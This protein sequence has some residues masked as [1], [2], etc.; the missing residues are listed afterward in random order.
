MKHA[1]PAAL[2]LTF[3]T[4]GRADVVVNEIMYHAP[5]DLDDLQFVELHN[6]GDKAVDL[7]GWQLKGAKHTFPAG[8]K[9]EANGYLVVCK[10]QKEF[11]RAY[12]FDAA[13]EF[14]GALSH[15]GE[16][17]ELLDATGKKLDG[18]KYKTR[19]PWPVAPDGESSSLERIC[20]TAPADTPDNWAPSPLAPGSP[21]PMGTPGKR[22]ATF[23]ASLPPVV[24]NVTHTPRH[25]LPNQEIKVTAEARSVAALKAVELLYRVAGNGSEKAETAIPM[26]K[27]ANGAYSATI[28]AQKA[29]LIVRFRVRATDASGAE[30]LHPHPNELRPAR[31]VY[32]HEKFEPGQIPLG[33]VVSCG[34]REFRDAQSDPGASFGRPPFPEPPA[35][36]NVAF[37][38]V[39]PKTAE[40]RLFDFITLTPRSAGRKLRFHKD[41]PLGDMTTANLIYEYH[42]RFPL[43]EHLAYETYRR[44]GVPCPQS[45]FVRTW[46]DG[47]PIGFQLLVQQ[48]NNAFL[49][50]HGVGTGGN[51][52]K[53]MWFGGTL[54]Q[55]H[56]KRNNPQT[57]HT[58]LTEMMDQLLKAR[59]DAQWDYIKKTFDA[60]GMVNLYA[61]RAILSDWD[62]YFNNYYLYHDT[63]KTGKWLMFPWDQDKTW[64][65]HDGIGGYDVFFDMPI[66]FGMEGDQPPPGSG[67]WWRPGGDVSKPLLANPQFR[68]HFLARTKELLETVYTE[69]AFEPV[70][71]VMAERLEAEVK[72]RAEA[73]RED[74]KRAVEHFRKNLD[75]FREHLTKRRAFLLKQDEIRKAGKYDP[76]ELK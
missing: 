18:L 5:N 42:D 62:G 51:L 12:G 10:S 70:F 66:T 15:G 41:D 22:N 36:G 1:L 9:I 47:R 55:R 21:R 19:A 34:A 71:K 27:G 14:K 29:G 30:R 37:V 58:D 39:D 48:P 6:T 74:P 64:G 60:P 13:G 40:P 32:V 2:L 56:E 4:V 75:V 59:G 24:S 63:A 61:T 33:Y 23:A 17:V 25:A 76:R 53:A 65:F 73:R 72:V 67:T 35:R 7:S 28:P 43:A 44:A 26:T 31:S 3:A 50:R 11:K 57:G 46:I 16:V 69:E 20:P 45:D 38:Y 68:K 49:R 54:V 52:Y 8:A